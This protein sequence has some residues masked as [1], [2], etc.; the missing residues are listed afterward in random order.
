M[1]ILRRIAFTIIGIFVVLQFIRPGRNTMD[2][3]SPH[4]INTRFAVPPEIQTVLRSSCYD[5]H[6]NNTRYPW[7]A[8]VQPVGWFLSDD[9]QNGKKHLN[10][11]EFGRY[12]VRQQFI[13]LSDIIEQ[14]DEEKMPLPAYLMIHTDARLS[15]A[16]KDLVIAWVRSAEDS[17]RAWY[18][19]D[20]L[21]GPRR[22]SRENRK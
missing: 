11:S 9:I 8:E 5:C 17:I 6:S 2:T 19:P 7:Y 10:F 14:I 21:A 20:S 12:T 4:D 1:R 3:P 18:P 22:A 13:R 15:S 16:Q